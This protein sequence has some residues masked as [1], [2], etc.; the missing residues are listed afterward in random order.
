MHLQTVMSEGAQSEE[1]HSE[2]EPFAL[3]LTKKFSFILKQYLEL[4]RAF[5]VLSFLHSLLPNLLG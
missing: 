3:G 5:S 4:H 1:A 2:T